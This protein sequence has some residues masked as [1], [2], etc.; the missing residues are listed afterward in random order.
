M[1]IVHPEWRGSRT[2]PTCLTWYVK[3]QW[4]KANSIN[5]ASTRNILAC[6]TDITIACILA[7]HLVSWR[8]YPGLPHT[9]PHFVQLRRRTGHPESDRLL[10]KVAKCMFHLIVFSEIL[11]S[12]YFRRSYGTDGYLHCCL[13]DAYS[14]FICEFSIHNSSRIILILVIDRRRHGY[15]PSVRLRMIH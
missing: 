13:G 2:N 14:H 5:S 1:V 11:L 12:I 7:H 6:I 9:S 4:S 15:V 3:E 8:F 10:V